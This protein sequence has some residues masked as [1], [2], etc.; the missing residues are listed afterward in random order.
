VFRLSIGSTR[1]VVPRAAG[2]RTKRKILSVAN[3]LFAKSGFEGVSMRDVGAAAHLPFASV[4]YHFGTKL[5]LYRAVFH[6]YCAPLMTE[7]VDRLRS[8]VLTASPLDDIGQIAAA[9]VEPIISIRDAE[10]G[11]DFAHLM[12][13]E[14]NDPQ[15][16]ER[17]IV[18]EYFDPVAR[19][20]IGLLRRA[21]PK[22]TKKRIYWAYHFAI[23]AIAVNHAGTGRIERLSHGVCQS[24]NTK[25]LRAELTQFVTVALVG[26]LCPQP[27]QKRLTRRR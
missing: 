13:R 12:A 22:V 10:G 23:G 2:E 3:E 16:F 26:T 9:I 15:E 20:A 27:E 1:K 4:T 19:V 5:G 11:L 25:E 17:G 6:Q 24:S 18:A 7:R 8:I 14:V 21:L